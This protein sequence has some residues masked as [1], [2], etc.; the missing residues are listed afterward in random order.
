MTE[1]DAL[2][3]SLLRQLRQQ[4]KLADLSFDTALENRRIGRKNQVCVW[5]KLSPA[6]FVPVSLDRSLQRAEL[7]VSLWICA[8]KSLGGGACV[9]AFSRVSDALLFGEN[10]LC[11]QTVSCGKAEYSEAAGAFRMEG[12]VGMTAYCRESG[13]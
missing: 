2:E 1:F 8:P 10:G 9:D 5:L 12:Q 11:L 6:R 3:Q 13:E 7:T 4:E